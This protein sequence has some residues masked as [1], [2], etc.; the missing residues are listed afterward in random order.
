MGVV[1]QG[2]YKEGSTSGFYVSSHSLEFL[3]IYQQNSDILYFS[4]GPENY[5]SCI[6][7]FSHMTFSHI[8]LFLQCLFSFS[9]SRFDGLDI[10]FYYREIKTIKENIHLLLQP[11]STNNL[12]LNPYNLRSP[13]IKLDECFF[14]L[15]KA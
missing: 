5:H 9:C 12:H 15:S 14:L 2:P 10:L 13:P 11:Y 3:I 6:R 1:A 8:V 7:Q 4:L